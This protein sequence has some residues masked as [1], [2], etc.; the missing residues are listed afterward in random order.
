MNSIDILLGSS[1]ANLSALG[2]SV[3]ISISNDD[4]KIAM[5]G[6]S[7]SNLN[8]GGVSA[9]I[10]IANINQSLNQLGISIGVSVLADDQQNWSNYWSII[11]KILTE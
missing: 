2:V 6:V 3:G 10:S 9:G 7:V 5:L 1:I 4:Q 8:Q 11:T